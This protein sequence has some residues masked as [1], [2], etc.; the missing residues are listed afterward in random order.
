M[1][2][3]IYIF[4]GLLII[5]ILIYVMWIYEL[6]TPNFLLVLK[7]N[8]N[9]K[10]LST[11][12]WIEQ[13]ALQNKYNG[14]IFI[15]NENRSLTFKNGY[16]SH[17]KE[18]LINE[19]TSFRLASVSKQFTAFAIML[20]KKESKIQ[21]ETPINTII[22]NFPNS[23]VTIRHLLNQTS[24]IKSDYMALAKNS[25]KSKRQIL[26]IDSATNLIC[27]NTPLD[28]KPLH[29]FFYNNSNYILLARVIEIVSGDSYEY[30][31]NKNVFQKL[32]LNET[33]VWTLFSKCSLKSRKNVAMG[34]E[35][36]FKSTPI[37]I[38]SSW[39]DGV[40]GDGAVFSSLKDLKNWLDKWD[41][42]ELL[43]EN[44]L[45][46]AFIKPILLDGSISPYG[47]GWLIESDCAWHTGKWLSYNSIILK[48]FVNDN[49][50]IALDNSSNLRFNKIIKNLTQTF[51]ENENL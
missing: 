49:S 1:S 29:S 15:N 35:S 28:I 30:F 3:L 31:M 9:D 21:Y 6:N 51:F 39:L 19:N 42:N 36:F 44:E 16:T 23:K 45:R 18:N 11:T 50:L 5:S 24:G 14:V 27:S 33:F 40:A 34:F 38:K 48:S 17:H 10:F 43:N 47:F 2:I 46:E 20:L 7:K 22:T 8:N 25:Y 4:L 26:S 13:L 12:K 41:G 37:E 32:N